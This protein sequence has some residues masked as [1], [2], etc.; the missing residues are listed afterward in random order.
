[1]ADA[2]P[3]LTLY[4]RTYCHLCDDM[5]R[6]LAPLAAEWGVE[7]RYVDVDADPAT[8]ARYGDDVPV[9]AHGDTTLCQHFLDPQRVRAYL[10]E[11]R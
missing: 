8:E 2:A 10:A 1:V 11:I 9:L 5:A 6:A 4:G 7:V 3:A